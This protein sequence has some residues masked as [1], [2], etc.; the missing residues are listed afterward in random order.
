MVAFLFALLSG[1]QIIEQ[2]VIMHFRYSAL[3]LSFTFLASLM[4]QQPQA[5]SPFANLPKDSQRR[6]LPRDMPRE[7]I[8]AA[9]NGKTISINY[10]RPSLE[11]RTVNDLLKKLP[12]DRMWRIGANQ[13]T[14]LTAE[15][16]LVAGGQIVP[17][18]KYSIYVYA[19]ESGDWQLA[20]NK[21]PGIE[22]GKLLPIVSPQVAHELWPRLDGYDKNIKNAEVARV[23]MKSG[24]NGNPTDI[25]TM[26]FA[27]SSRGI[28]LTMSWGDRS[29]TAEFDAK[30]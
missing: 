30:K 15:T 13:V 10:G 29:W 6:I 20:L 28:L 9:L 26:K 21:D 2:G 16:D 23:G 8:S 4:A 7:T 1:P 5:G 17:A 14:V 11:G 22:L 12:G 24:S 19:P 25:F 3:I 27:P 18:G